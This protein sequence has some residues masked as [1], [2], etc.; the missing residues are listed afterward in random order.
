M[1]SIALLALLWFAAGLALPA[2]SPSS[3]G[4]S[5]SSSDS[6][7]T[8]DGGGDGDGDG[9]SDGTAACAEGVTIS[10]TAALSSTMLPGPTITNPGGYPQDGRAFLIGAPSQQAT[11]DSSTG[12]F[13]LVL[14]AAQLEAASMACG[15]S[16]KLLAWWP[17]QSFVEVAGA[18]ADLVLDDAV[19]TGTVTLDWTKANHVLITDLAPDTLTAVSFPGI[20]DAANGFDMARL[21]SGRDFDSN[22][23]PP[24]TY[25]I[26]IVTDLGA[27]ASELAFAEPAPGAAQ[28]QWD[29][30]DITMRD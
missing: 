7:G 27:Y 1:R 23:L 21:E 13:S 9:D 24:G 17:A 3:D 30:P 26:E 6:S 20:D 15:D 11:V 22:Y 8:D 12:E 4:G 29:S 25:E 5:D 28:D 10:G 19:D 2:C 14:T 16:V 18:T